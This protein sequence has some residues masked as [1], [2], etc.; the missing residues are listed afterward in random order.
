MKVMDA[1]TSQVIAV[2]IF[3]LLVTLLP[4]LLNRF[5][6]SRSGGIRTT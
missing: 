4:G 1:F 6:D 2:I 5:A 3:G